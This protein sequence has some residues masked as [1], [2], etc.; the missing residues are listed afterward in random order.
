[1]K[2]ATRIF[3]FPLIL[4]VGTKDRTKLLDILE[5]YGIGGTVKNFF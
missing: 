4:I 1:M 2:I 3:N 5:C